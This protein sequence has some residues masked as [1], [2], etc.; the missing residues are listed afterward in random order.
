MERKMKEKWVPH[1]IAVGAFV[2]FIVLGLACASTSGSSGDSAPSSVNFGMKNDNQ[3]GESLSVSFE[4]NFER[5][6]C[7]ACS[8]R[9]S[10]RP[11]TLLLRIDNGS[12][13]TLKISKVNSLNS[14]MIEFAVS[15]AILDQ[16]LNCNNSIDLEF[17]N[18][19]EYIRKWHVSSEDDEAEIR[20]AARYNDTPRPKGPMGIK[21]LINYW[22][23]R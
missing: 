15:P 10:R 7:F 2:V 3:N 12:P 13:I 21:N 11:D 9:G 14:G 1:F 16:L 23:N 19:Y 22:N 6:F 17:N 8:Y 20:R 4:R 18:T 5:Q